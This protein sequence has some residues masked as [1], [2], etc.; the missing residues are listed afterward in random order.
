MRAW[1]RLNLWSGRRR[2]R[3]L[4]HMP[5][6]LLRALHSSLVGLYCGG[7]IGLSVRF[8]L[9]LHEHALLLLSR[10]HLLALSLSLRS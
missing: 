1:L 7:S 2:R 8:D 3:H 9:L 4:L 6:L 10:Q 5:T